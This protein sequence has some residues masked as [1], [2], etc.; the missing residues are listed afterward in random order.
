[1]TETTT[2]RLEAFIQLDGDRRFGGKAG[3]PWYHAYVSDGGRIVWRT[4]RSVE[5][6]EAA[7]EKAYEALL[8]LRETGSAYGGVDLETLEP[9]KPPKKKER[10]AAL[11]EQH[12]GGLFPKPK[13]P[14]K[15]KAA[16]R[17]AP[18]VPVELP[19]YGKGI[20][21]EPFS[22]RRAD[23]VILERDG[24]AA[25]LGF[26]DPVSEIYRMKAHYYR[27]GYEIGEDEYQ[28]IYD[29]GAR[30]VEADYS[31]KISRW[32]LVAPTS[33]FE[34]LEIEHTP[35][36]PRR[37]LEHEEWVKEGVE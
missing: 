20:E 35:N 2:E 13:E 23:R 29:R 18:S 37:I 4:E 28:E 33:A 14:K 27:G 34:N 32:I 9:V 30:Y 10:L 22:V 25:A 11:E 5:G 7:R 16:R 12:G 3:G 6:A 36:G 19:A 31:S 24:G 1:M 26:F 17:S 15:A 21:R 8:S